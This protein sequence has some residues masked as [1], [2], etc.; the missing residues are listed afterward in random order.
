ML[1]LATV[2][3]AALA[4][5]GEILREIAEIAQGQSGKTGWRADS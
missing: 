4:P 2:S 5:N 1:L 3:T